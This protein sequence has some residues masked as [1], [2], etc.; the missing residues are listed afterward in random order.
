M[1]TFDTFALKNAL[2]SIDEDLKE[3]KVSQPQESFAESLRP[4]ENSKKAAVKNLGTLLQAGVK[5]KYLTNAQKNVDTNE[6]RDNKK[7]AMKALIPEPI[8]LKSVKQETPRASEVLFDQPN[9]DAPM[10]VNDREAF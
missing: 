5:E 8:V 3:S 1:N 4:N 9:E 10:D 6:A 7:K 2:S